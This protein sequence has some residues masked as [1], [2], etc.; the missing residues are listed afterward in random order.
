MITKK[1]MSIVESKDIGEG[2]IIEEFSI[3]REGAKIGKN[4][5][6]F[7]HAVIE[8]GVLIK[9]NSRIY[10]G[11]Y[12]GKTPDGAGALSRKPS[13]DKHITIGNNC[14][15]GPNA[16]IYYDVSIGSH[17]LVGDGASVRENCRIG[18][19]CIISRYVTI[20]Y[21]TKI[22]N[23]TKIMDL[24][25]ITGNATIG[26]NVF[27]GM[28]V[29]TANDNDLIKRKYSGDDAG[30]TI[31]DG[32]SIGEGASILPR[33]ILGKGSFV[34]AGAVVTKDVPENVVVVGVPAMIKKNLT[35]D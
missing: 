22:G 28:L 11:T 21:N 33:V 10:P 9:D 26:S 18:S 4:V 23:K 14:A 32:V 1:K 19:Y 16:I 34:A 20:N 2:T 15:I 3:V 17:T 8:N 13:F 6:I 12:I 5:H 35:K 25:H 7:P 31:Q 24:T 30:P 29:S 27:I